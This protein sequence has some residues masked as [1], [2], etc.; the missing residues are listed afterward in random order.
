VA[1][2]AEQPSS[3]FNTGFKDVDVKPGHRARLLRPQVRLELHFLEQSVWFKPVS[4]GLFHDL[5]EFVASGKE[6][7]K[8]F[9]E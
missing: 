7:R 9:V 3:G 6:T 4:D 1:S 2:E 5:F 8:S